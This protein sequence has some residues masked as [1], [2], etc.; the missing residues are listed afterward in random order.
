VNRGTAQSRGLT[1]AEIVL[2]LGLL[3]IMMLG[4]IRLFT[5]LLASSSKN[6]RTLVGS[7]FASQKLEEV[8]ASGIYSNASGNLAAYTVDASTQTQFYY[9]VRC[10]A[11][12]ASLTNPDVSYLGGYVVTVQ[13]WWNSDSPQ[14]ARPGVGLQTAQVQRFFYPR[15]QV[16]GP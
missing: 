12:S 8:I 13:V 15:T 16:N 11:L 5:A 6:T 9:Q 1:I 10:D 14:R 2:S 3:S 4:L 7:Q